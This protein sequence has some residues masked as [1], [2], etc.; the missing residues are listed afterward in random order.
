[1]ISGNYRLANFK[2]DVSIDIELYDANGMM[3]DTITKSLFVRER[4]TVIMLKG[5][6]ELGYQYVAGK[7]VSIHLYNV[8]EYGS[9]TNFG[10]F[11]LFLEKEG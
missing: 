7:K 9:Y 2:K 4:G 8:G 1:M 3:I 10:H 6:V 5:V 11:I